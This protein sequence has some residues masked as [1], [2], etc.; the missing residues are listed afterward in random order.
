MG[1]TSTLLQDL[2]HIRT[3]P[4]PE[5]ASRAAR[6][7]LL[8]TLG[9]IL[10]GARMEQARLSSWITAS[11]NRGGPAP[12]IGFGQTGDPTLAAV[13]NGTSA[14]VAELDDGNRF[15]MVH[16]GAPVNSALLS[17][18]GAAQLSDEDILIGLVVGYETTIRIAR[19]VQPYAKDRGLHAT[20]ICGAVGAATGVA[21]A[22]RLDKDG[23]C[24]ALAGGATGAG[25]L[26]KVIRGQSQLKAYNAGQA[27][28]SGLSA[29]LLAQAGF[30]GP[31]DVLDGPHGFL[32]IVSGVPELPDTALDSTGK[33][34]VNDIYVKPYA[35]CRHCHAPVEAALDLRREHGLCFEDIHTVRVRSHR[36]A[37]YMHDHTEI[38]GSQSGK[39]SIPY[40]V[41]VTLVTGETGMDAFAAACLEDPRVIDLTRR[42]IVEEDAKL[43]ALVP[44]KRS[45]ILEITCHDG[46]MIERHI[47]LPKGEPETALSAQDVLDKFI[48]LAVFG[49][50]SRARAMTLAG[51][52]LSP[53]AA[54]GI[55]DSIATL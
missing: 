6:L 41:A 16:P 9:C 34:G 22:L 40:C 42:V 27:A 48:D 38:N 52:M 43:T 3:T 4:L 26:L 10:A 11:G 36:M 37:V 5:E 54:S 18:A 33:L 1:L 45:A 19:A 13:I 14:H 30:L 23:L 55:T 17:Q 21:A 28:Q 25:G 49:G 7:C 12:F 29:A 35:S 8:D 32:S 46:R 50:L 53:D 15:G 31:L 44:V 24:A 51:H 47:D 20:G 2:Q 39:M